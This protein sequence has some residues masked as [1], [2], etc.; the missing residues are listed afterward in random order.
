Y[1]AQLE[2]KVEERTREL[3]AS[4]EKY[5]D[6]VEEL[7]DVVFSVDQN[8]A[9]TYLSPA[10]ESMTGYSVSELMGRT[11][12]DFLHPDDLTPALENFMRT[13]SGET[14]VGEL[15]FFTRSGE[16]RWLRNS[17]K[18]IFVEDRVVGV[19]GVFSDITERKKAEELLHQS[20]DQLDLLLNASSHVLY[21]CEAFGDFDATYISSNIEPILGYTQDDFLQKGFWASKIHPEDA[22][23][24]FAELSQLF[25]HGFHKHE[26]RFQHKDGTWRWMYDELKLDRDEKGNAKDILGSIVDITERKQAEAEL[27]ASGTKFRELFESMSNAVAV[28]EARENGN[29]FVFKDFNRSG[30]QIEK[31]KRQDIIG[32]SVLEVFPGVKDF[33]LF[34]V[35]QRVWRTGKPEH[36]PVS[37]YKDERIVG[38]RD[39]YVYKL[40]TGE[41]VAVYDDATERKRAEEVLK[42]SEERYRLL[43]ETANEAIIVAQDGMLKFA[44]PRTSELT[45]YS[46]QELL[47]MPFAQLIHPDDR[48]MVVERHLKRLA[49]EVPPEVYP[50]RYVA[51]DGS[52]GWVDINAVRIEWEGRPATLNFLADITERRR[53]EETL[54]QAME[55]L[56]R[57]NA[58]L[59][60]FAYV[61]SHDLQE[62]LRMVA[63]YTQLLEKRYKDRLDADAN[64]F[65]D[66]AVDGARRMQQLINDLLAYSR[67]GTRGKPFEPTD[68]E[69]AFEGALANL[70]VAIKE[71]KAKVTHDP[72]PTV[73]G[74]DTQLVQV[75][76]NL[77]HNAIKFR[78]QKPPAVHVSA[79][80]KADEW[81]FSVKDNGIGID[82]QYSERVF[83]IF[84]RLHR[85]AY[86]G[87]GIGLSIANRILQRHGGRMW[88]ESKP[89]KGSTFYFTIKAT[90]VRQK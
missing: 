72:L 1:A 71:S 42:Q 5:R 26:Y 74:D 2:Q 54:K 36:H 20:L 37:F 23:R 25:E 62:P 43:V 27:I 6:L 51:K 56:Q 84:Q 46:N 35:F 80:R 13:L 63:S 90:G 29:D 77:I 17:N 79:E 18:P 31:I 50:F 78:S 87:T 32:K 86:P 30:E 69:A 70:Q 9:M 19:R 24:I 16:L 88:L 55:E 59:E 89:G 41:V 73:M 47:S 3:Q 45:G 33:G 21:R 11:F 67:V 53:A 7:P 57:S 49:G 68:M 40:P 76:Q 81:V 8:G 83:L 22:P 15:R 14:V 61:A 66:Y 64:E 4:E 48:D 58:E 39:N 65:I 28:Y 82:P 12:A 75:F 60:R 10:V 38:W 52:V 85:E 34:E 44:N